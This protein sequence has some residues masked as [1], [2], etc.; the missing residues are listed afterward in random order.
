[1]DYPNLRKLLKTLGDEEEFGEVLENP[2]WPAD[3]A[4]LEAQASRLSNDDEFLIMVSGPADPQQI[5]VSSKHLE[6]LSSF[7]ND[8]FDATQEDFFTGNSIMRRS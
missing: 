8:A 7:L 4:L 3:V 5:L 1:M 2:L 6:L